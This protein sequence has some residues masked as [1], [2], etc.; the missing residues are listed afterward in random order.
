MNE[1]FSVKVKVTKVT[2][3]GWLIKMTEW[4][5]NGDNLT[6]L[7]TEEDIVN[8]GDD[9][10]YSRFVP[11]KGNR[12]AAFNAVWFAIIFAGLDDIARPYLKHQLKSCTAWGAAYRFCKEYLGKRGC[13]LKT[14]D[15]GS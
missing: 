6:I 13:N 8:I 15:L 14:L 11:S 12:D 1:K 7:V 10:L 4:D 9:E 2:S 3:V 5:T